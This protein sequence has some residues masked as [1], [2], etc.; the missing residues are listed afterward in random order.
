MIKIEVTGNSLG[1]VADKMLA[2]G[3]SLLASDHQRIREKGARAEAR[4][5]KVELAEIDKTIAE[6][7]STPTPAAS[8]SEEL[9]VVDLPVADTPTIDF[10]TDIR[11]LILEVVT[12]RGKPFMEDILSSFGVVKASHIEPARLPE[13]VALMQEALGQ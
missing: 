13:L 9:E 11:A 7:K 1:E 5:T 12:K 2:I 4:F 10:E 6:L 3:S 8:V